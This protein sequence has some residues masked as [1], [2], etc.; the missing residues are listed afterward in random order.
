MQS[1]HITVYY[2][3]FIYVVSH[4]CYNLGSKPALRIHN[5]YAITPLHHA[6][7]QFLF[8]Q[9]LLTRILF[10]KTHSCLPHKQALSLKHAS[11]V[12]KLCT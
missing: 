10:I 12:H 4:S 11:H 8:F 3:L 9:I 7:P 6:E 2:F 5:T 1:F